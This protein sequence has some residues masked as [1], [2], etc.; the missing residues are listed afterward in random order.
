M[1]K[2]LKKVLCLALAG[3]M[4]L[5]L[6]ACGGGNDE[7]KLAAE[8]FKY[9]QANHDAKSA[10]VYAA[11]LGEFATAYAAAKEATTVSE[12]FAL[13]AI[14][15]A[16]LLESG[17][18]VP[19][20][21]QGGTYAIT[22]VAPRTATTTLWGSDVER[23][24]NV[25]V[26]TELIT[27]AERK[28]MIAKW[29]E[30][31]N[32]P[33]VN[34]Y[35]EWVENYLK[36]KGYTLKDSYAVAYTGDPETWD[37]IGS[38]R[39]TTSDVMVQ[40]YDGLMEYNMENEQVYA[41]AESHT[42]SEDGLT[43]TFKIRKGATWV[44]SQGTYFANVTA[45]DFVTGMQHVLDAG[46]DGLGYLVQGVIKNAT[47]YMNGD[48]TDFTQVGVKAVDDY[49]VEYTLEAPCSYFMTM[50]GY[51]VFAPMNKEYYV[52]KGGQF[53][54][55]YDPSAESYTYGSSKDDIV[56]CGPFIVT[57]FT[58]TNT[59]AFTANESYWNKD[60]VNIKSY[61]MKYND[62]SDTSKGYNDAVAGTVDGI[63]LN[64]ATIETCKKDNRFD[65]YAYVTDTNATSYMSFYNLN[66]AVFAN[67]N[68]ATAAVS[69]Q[70]TVDAERT[71][72]AMSNQNFRL[73]ISYA[74][75]RVS[76]NAVQVG[77]EVA[78]Y[79]VRN[80]YTPGNFVTLE[81][82]VTVKIN[83]TDKTYPAGTY[84]GQIM[85]DQLDAD[86]SAIKAWD[87]ANNTSDGYDGWYNPTEAV[88]ELDKAIEALAKDG[89]EISKENP[90]YLDL[91]YFSGS[92]L[93][94]QMANSYKKSV[95]ASLDGKVIINLVE[96]TSADQ[97][98]YTG[99]YTDYGYQ[100]NYDIFDLS[101]WGPDY[102]DPQTY[103]DT[104]LDEYA[105]YMAKCLGIY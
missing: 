63:A 50:L 99:Y 103:L 4:T 53:G 79:S 67:A 94:T 54:T 84:Y 27:A 86:G 88:K 87:A 65:T 81:E 58:A 48:I 71:N 85:Q 44:D 25:V 32:N 1:K 60:N 57:N 37:V 3:V 46:D 68:D 66:R 52:S 2:N 83:G 7:A 15:E 41:L 20:Q 9:D 95:E 47:Q 18:M 11:A 90:I 89:V 39:A 72:K 101:G 49:T 62:G 26:T 102:G 17:V 24:H 61:T 10:D 35:E 73:A 75:D 38:S 28:E 40:C 91:P 36:S 97:W 33:E 43:Y 70:T 16:K 76:W 29:N 6:A 31:A 13:M 21:T 5:S 30:F 42:V 51:S 100:S 77:D 74:F 82:E 104:M 59:I 92:E 56:Y 64:V 22:R 69:K 19:T 80:T 98:Y 93:R 96:C 45:H 14:A 8:A 55:E 78:A 23:I 105:G 34:G 12:K